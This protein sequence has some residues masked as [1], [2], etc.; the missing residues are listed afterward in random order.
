MKQGDDIY[1]IFVCELQGCSS[2]C[3]CI[4]HIKTDHLIGWHLDSVNYDVAFE[5]SFAA[6]EVAFEWSRAS[7]GLD[8]GAPNLWAHTTGDKC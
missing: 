1:G 8:N 3:V 2:Y 6:S 4:V 5:V 7:K